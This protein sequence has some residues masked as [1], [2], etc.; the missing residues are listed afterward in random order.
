MPPTPQS[1]VR[2]HGI[3][4]GSPAALPVYYFGAFDCK[5]CGSGW[6]T[7]RGIA[8]SHAGKIRIEFLHHFPEADADMFS[9]ALEAECAA[10]QGRFADYAEWR[11]SPMRLGSA[12]D[13]VGLDRDRLR[14]CMSDPQTAV[15]VLEDT[16]EAL[17]LGFRGEVPSWVI[18]TQLRRG[19]QGQAVI[20][21]I[22]DEQIA[23]REHLTAAP[24]QPA[25]IPEPPE[26]PEPAPL[27]PTQATGEREAAPRAATA[28]SVAG[29][30]DDGPRDTAPGPR[31]R[32]GR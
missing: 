30:T 15:S 28:T 22:I 2:A 10:R 13:A 21:R 3:P 12:A 18:G 6:Q 31:L 17:R 11:T 27:A 14:A 4:S 24:G 8:A 32:Y 29:T 5:N 25:A 20:E 23:A 9:A 1:T 7:L 26:P 19:V 16:S